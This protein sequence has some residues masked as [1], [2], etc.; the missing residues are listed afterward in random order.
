MP[1]SQAGFETQDEY[2][3]AVERI[4][5][6]A[7]VYEN[8]PDMPLMD[9]YA[10]DMLM[11]KLASTEIEH[12]QWKLRDTP[13]EKVGA[14]VNIN[15]D[16]LHSAP[17]LSLDNVFNVE[18][19]N[20]W[21]ERLGR[22]LGHNA[23][24]YV[25]EP[26]LD[27]LALSARY[28]KGKLAMLLLRGSG[29][30]GE[31]VSYNA[32]LIRGLPAQLNEPITIEVRGEC[33][34]SDK[35]FEQ[36]NAAREAN[37]DLPFVNPRN[38]A[39]GALRAKERNYDIP[40]TFYAYALVGHDDLDHSEAMRY[41]NSLGVQTTAQ[42]SAGM[43]EAKNIA[44]VIEA[45]GALEKKRSTLGFAVDG[46]VVKADK[47]QERIKAGFTSRAPRWGIAWKYPADTRT[48]KLLDIEL[49][50]GRTGA[51][52]PVAVLEPVFVGGTT[53]SSV[54]L[55]NASEIARKD[56]RIGDTVWVRRAGEVIPEI[57]AVNVKERKEGAEPWVPPT[58][59]PRCEAELNTTQ[60]VWRCTRGK[61]CG[62]SEA[63]YYY[64]SK[65]C[66]DVQMIGKVLARA[67]VDK[68][69]VEDPS[70]LY[71]LTVEQLTDIER[72]GNLK[73]QKVLD[74]LEKSKSQPLARVFAGL[75]IRHSGVRMSATIASHFGSMEAIEAA[76]VEDFE[77]IDGVGPERAK[78]ITTELAELKNVIENLRQAGV[79]MLEPGFGE[80]D[81]APKPLRKKDGTPMSVVVTGSIEGLGRI[82]AQEAVVRLGGKPSGSVSKATDVVVIGENPGSKAAKAQDLQSQGSSIKI[83]TGKEFLELL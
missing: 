80:K 26:K 15:G 5:E 20:A 40:L 49:Q 12:P 21:N 64:A 55:H 47:A 48:T 63:I 33:F 68:G 74:Q 83:L 43:A 24:K 53:I 14:G 46:A 17:M 44:E 59:C 18:E 75:G 10:Y 81:N 56:I 23:T 11:R 72:M 35:D 9:D 67:L 2:T 36:A 77:K 62:I 38:G 65:P 66:L 4:R 7:R 42:S 1:Q 60:K 27:G 3:Q 37:G 51:V 30:A 58:K 76:S 31:D 28:E 34:M 82:E 57:V 16:V 22:A 79:N 52:T 71:K 78:F 45:I 70:D 25:I 41:I 32:R 50:L 29:S 39:S 19:L 73:A 61:A 13:T 8:T 6:A 54:T 69:L